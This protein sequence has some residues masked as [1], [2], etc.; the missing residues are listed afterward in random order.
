MPEGVGGWLV[1]ALVTKIQDGGTY[2]YKDIAVNRSFS[3]SRNK[4]KIGNCLAEQT[5]E[6]EML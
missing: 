4:N 6:N 5:Q 3:L 2:R 1:Y